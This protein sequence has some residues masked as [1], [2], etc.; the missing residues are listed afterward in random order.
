MALVDF[1]IVG[2]PKCGTTSLHRYLD[3]HDQIF[4]SRPKETNF[5][6][7]KALEMD[8]LYY[9]EKNITSKE[10]Y[11]RV[12]SGAG[13]SQ[14]KGEA[15]VSY[16]FYSDVPG[17]IFKHN[18][19]AKII[20]VLRD[21]V[22][23]AHSHFLMDQR[24]GYTSSTFEEIFDDTKSSPLNYQQYF[25]LSQYYEQVKRYLDTFGLGQVLVLLDT[26]LKK[27]F[28]KTMAETC[29]F[30]GVEHRDNLSTGKR[31][32]AYKEPRSGLVAFFYKIGFLRR[33]IQNV[34]PKVFSDYIKLQLFDSATKPMIGERLKSRLYSFY[35]DDVC[36][37]E[38]L[39][40][41]DLG[42]WRRS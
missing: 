8:G 35:N 33:L 21:P 9:G 38:A 12:F 4:M 25:Q 34:I 13:S 24:L 29:S 31:H 10:S 22:E 40:G 5:F 20:I 7:G 26:D 11:E 39:I 6:S 27:D 1:F 30:L 41:R 28:D 36:K 16:L 14:L 32:N 2:A 15:S 23:R 19:L 18:S 42:H 37:L 17:E 3:E